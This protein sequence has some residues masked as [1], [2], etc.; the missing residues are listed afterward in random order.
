MP[1]PPATHEQAQK[2]RGRRLEAG[3]TA[4]CVAAAAVAVRDPRVRRPR[5]ASPG[6]GRRNVPP[7]PSSTT[8]QGLT[9]AGRRRPPPQLLRR[10]PE[11]ERQ[12]A[13]LLACGVCGPVP[14]GPALSLLWQRCLGRHC[15]SD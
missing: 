6:G 10:D 8:K 14:A 12:P 13:V 9:A 7:A 15:R 2:P 4:D 1:P 3:P 11:R 5:A